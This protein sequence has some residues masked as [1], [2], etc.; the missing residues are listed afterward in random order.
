VLL[1]SARPIFGHS[2]ILR[3]HCIDD[4]LTEAKMQDALHQ[5]FGHLVSFLS[6][7][8]KEVWVAVCALPII[9][10]SFSARTAVT[11]V[12][13]VV[14]V[15][16]SVLIVLEPQSAHLI[17]AASVYSAGILVAIYGIRIGRKESASDTLA[18]L[19]DLE[20]T[21]EDLRRAEEKRFLTELHNND[22][23]RNVLMPW[24]P[25]KLDKPAAKRRSKKPSKEKEVVQVAS[26][27]NEHYPALSP[28]E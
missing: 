18:K 25:M 22:H 1:R 4:P 23:S 12:G 6:I 5:L 2:F 19:A 26:E 17:F 16:V 21:L 20:L 3:L 9:V 24:P 28:A 8:P 10:A 13:S 14:A 7:V 11:I 15:A 27:P